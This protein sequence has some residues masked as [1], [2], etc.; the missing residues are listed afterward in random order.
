MLSYLETVTQGDTQQDTGT[1]RLQ[2]TDRY[3]ALMQHKKGGYALVAMCS[4]RR[5]GLNEAHRNGQEAPYGLHAAVAA[6][7]VPERDTRARPARAVVRIH[8]R[9]GAPPG[10]PRRAFA[11]AYIGPCMRAAHSR[12]QHVPAQRAGAIGIAWF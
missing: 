8:K 12:K 3:V 1:S 6:A 4:M 9:A 2:T 5:A 11:S 7:R 10:P